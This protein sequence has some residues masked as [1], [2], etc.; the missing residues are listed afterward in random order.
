MTEMKAT[1]RE[2]G[3]PV[4]RC[5]QSREPRAGQTGVWHFTFCD[6]SVHEECRPLQLTEAITAATG[7]P[8]FE[9]L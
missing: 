3:V 5:A 1:H 6:V 8:P 9:V 2:P 4:P 7:S